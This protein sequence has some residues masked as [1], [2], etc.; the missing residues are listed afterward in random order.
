MALAVPPSALV[1]TCLQGSADAFVQGSVLTG[2][3][4]RIAYRLAGVAW[5]LT[6]NVANVTASELSFCISRR[7]KTAMPLISDADVIIKFGWQANFA[8]SGMM[9]TDRNGYWIPPFDVPIVEETLYGILDST[10]TTVANNL[11]FRLDVTT[12]T[13][14]DIDRLN[15]I[16]R[17]LT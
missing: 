12:D 16:T 8:T 3:S 4:G 17:S 2:L 5:E 1:I 9:N 10:A 6:T 13:M 11:I 15:L 14:S 7:S